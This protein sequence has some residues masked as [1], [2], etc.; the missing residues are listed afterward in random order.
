MPNVASDA[1]GRTRTA[2]GSIERARSS[3]MH[4]SLC[5]RCPSGRFQSR[6]AWRGARS[7]API[8]IYL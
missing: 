1:V 8:Q 2:P 4:Q 3:S 7:A 6:G 5:I